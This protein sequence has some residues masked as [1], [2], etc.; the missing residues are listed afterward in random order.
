M[1]ICE[2]PSGFIDDL[3]FPAITTHV[4]GRLLGAFAR[5][6]ATPF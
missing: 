4:F 3:A 2:P 1:V 5:Q 6:L